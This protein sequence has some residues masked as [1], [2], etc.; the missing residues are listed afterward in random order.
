M[1]PLF[2]KYDR[3]EFALIGIH[4]LNLCVFNDCELF[5]G[6]IE[7]SQDDI[8]STISFVIEYLVEEN[9]VFLLKD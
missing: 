5:S 9:A 6:K 2:E 8:L 7:A 4:I 3:E 1:F